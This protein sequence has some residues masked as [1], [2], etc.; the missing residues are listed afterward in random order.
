[1]TGDQQWAIDVA[2]RA[3]LSLAA[4]GPLCRQGDTGPL[5]PYLPHADIL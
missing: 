2:H 3:G 5:A 4:M 1:M